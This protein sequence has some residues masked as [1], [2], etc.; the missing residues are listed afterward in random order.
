MSHFD[1]WCI[2]FS[3]LWRIGRW[4]GPAIGVGVFT[5]GMNVRESEAYGLFLVG[6]MIY[7][8]SLYFWS[9]A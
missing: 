2:I 7:F 6:G 3:D 9:F 8:A 5:L 4:F 1:A